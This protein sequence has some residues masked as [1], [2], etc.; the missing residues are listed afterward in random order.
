MV[1]NSIIGKNNK[2]K[3][4]IQMNS[5]LLMVAH[6][7]W[8]QLYKCYNREMEFEDLE[9]LHH[10]IEETLVSFKTD[11]AY[12]Q[13]IKYFQDRIRFYYSL[14]QEEQFIELSLFGFS[15]KVQEPLYDDS[16]GSWRHSD[17]CFWY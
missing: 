6:Y 3:G 16:C 14:D 9:M 4:E 17:Y 7:S 10:S 15:N 5:L 13:Y 12:F 1:Y 8:S 11:G 2:T